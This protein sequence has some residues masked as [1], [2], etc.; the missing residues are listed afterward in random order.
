MLMNVGLSNLIIALFRSEIGG[1]PT[2]TESAAAG[3]SDVTLLENVAAGQQQA[4]AT[5]FE[6]YGGMVFSVALRVLNDA[7]RAEDLMQEVFLQLWREPGK[8]SSGRGSLGAWLAV[9]A[10]NRAVDVVRGRK[11]SDPVEGV[12][13]AARTDLA[14]DVERDLLM[15]KVRAALKDLPL[16]QQ[17]SLELAYFEGLSH[18]EIAARTGDPLGTVKTRIRAALGSLRKAVEV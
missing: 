13:L 5:L 8:F 6:R 1:S 3:E 11:P 14:S 10:R 18:S 4:M 7:A 9:V 17:R 12:V 15:E 16:E 2:P